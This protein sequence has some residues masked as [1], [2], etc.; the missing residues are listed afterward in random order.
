MLTRSI[1]CGAP[2]GRLRRSYPPTCRLKSR[3]PSL[4]PCALVYS[5][6]G[7]RDAARPRKPAIRNDA[8]RASSI[9]Q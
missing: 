7:S 5:T 1:H 6:R 4:T 2:S 9:L 3:E 8:L